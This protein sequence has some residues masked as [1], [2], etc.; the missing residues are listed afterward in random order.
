MLNSFLQAAHVVVFP[1]LHVVGWI[2]GWK[3]KLAL[4]SYNDFRAN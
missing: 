2:A 3:M 4:T 1:R